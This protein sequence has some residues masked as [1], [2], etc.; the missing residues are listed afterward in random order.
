MPIWFTVNAP[1]VQIPLPA[2]AVVSLALGFFQDLGSVHVLGEPPVDWVEGMAITVA[3]FI[4]VCVFQLLPFCAR[5]PPFSKVMVCSL[6]IGKGQAVPHCFR[7]QSQVQRIRGIQ[8]VQHHKNVGYNGC[9]VLRERA[10][11]EG[12]DARGFYAPNAHTDRFMLSGAS[13][14]PDPGQRRFPQYDR[15]QSQ[16]AFG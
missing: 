3:V 2:A 9:I 16:R 13:R 7:P 10:E 14:H 6:T 5:R 15:G 1:F 8:R 11:C 12:T 4:V